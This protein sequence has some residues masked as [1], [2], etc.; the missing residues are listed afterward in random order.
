MASQDLVRYCCVRQRM[1]AEWRVANSQVARHIAA[2]LLDALQLASATLVMCGA[3][4]SQ[5]YFEADFERKFLLARVDPLI[6]EGLVGESIYDSPCVRWP[7]PASARLHSDF[8]NTNTAFLPT[9][10][11]SV[12]RKASS[13]VMISR[14]KRKSP[15]TFRGGL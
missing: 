5:P 7:M 14:G 12:R 1:S 9:P 8:N 10:E 15:R 13:G 4:M 2:V 11:I 6:L 3:Q